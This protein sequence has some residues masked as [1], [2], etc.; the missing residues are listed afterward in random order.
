MAAHERVLTITVHS[1]TQFPISSYSREMQK[2][3][4]YKDQ[5]H[6]K[7][8]EDGA[9]HSDMLMGMELGSATLSNGLPV[10]YN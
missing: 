6:T 8:R 10:P 5:H 4:N 1:Q 7:W 3:L 2:V 9:V